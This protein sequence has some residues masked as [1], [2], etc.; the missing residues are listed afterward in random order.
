MSFFIFFF[1]VFN[2]LFLV[3]HHYIQRYNLHI[4]KLKPWFPLLC[5]LKTVCIYVAS[6]IIKIN[7]SIFT[8][9][10]QAPLKPISSLIDHKTLWGQDCLCFVL[11][12]FVYFFFFYH[13]LLSL[14]KLSTLHVTG[15]KLI[16]FQDSKPYRHM[17]RW[18][19][20]NATSG[21]KKENCSGKLYV[22]KKC[23]LY[24]LNFICSI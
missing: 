12:L 2:L 17:K 9:F 14:N 8:E 6:T 16:F 18:I 7:I 11:F 20:Q 5:V 3:I 23:S 24:K 10:S 21:C 19:E 22:I 13:Y 15:I 4:I 1:T